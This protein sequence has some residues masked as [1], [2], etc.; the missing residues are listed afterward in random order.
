MNPV[1]VS[2][3]SG[4]ADWATRAAASE[5]DHLTTRMVAD[6]VS[7]RE[8]SFDALLGRLE[9]SGEDEAR[10]AAEMLVAS[11]LIVPILS[12]LRDTSRAQPPFAPGDAEQRFGP[13]LDVQIADR[14][15][16]A[17][18]FHI[19]DGIVQRYAAKTEH[20]VIAKPQARVDARG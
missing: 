13:L 9:D 18:N 8:P 7:R 5:G 3:F 14:I 15:I 6:D 10:E 4:L 19:V 16:H 11:A 20:A 17:A 1:A 12:D 2:N